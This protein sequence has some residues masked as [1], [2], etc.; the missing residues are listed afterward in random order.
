MGECGSLNSMCVLRDMIIKQSWTPGSVFKFT[1]L[2]RRIS[3]II[4]DSRVFRRA[5]YLKIRLY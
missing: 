2:Y 5:I 3:I 4:T 1:H